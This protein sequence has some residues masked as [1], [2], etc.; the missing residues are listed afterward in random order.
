[1]VSV[2]LHKFH[3]TDALNIFKHGFQS[4]T[5][6]RSLKCHLIPTMM[7]IPTVFVCWF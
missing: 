4:L 1:M 5:F 7:L 6:P 2:D 3:R